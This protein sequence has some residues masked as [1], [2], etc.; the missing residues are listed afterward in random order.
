MVDPLRGNPGWLRRLDEPSC[1]RRG[2]Q[3]LEQQGSLGPYGRSRAREVSRPHG[4]SLASRHLQRGLGRGQPD[5]CDWKL[6][7]GSSPCGPDCVRVRTRAPDQDLFFGP[8]CTGAAGY[9][10]NGPPD[11]NNH[12]DPDNEVR[13]NRSCNSERE[14]DKRALV[15]QE[16]GHALGLAHADTR[17]SCMWERASEADTTPG[18]HQYYMLNQQ[19]Y[20]H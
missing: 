17:Q 2:G 18:P 1:L 16:L 11:S 5:R 4:K 7:D 15:C 8:N 12:W 14:R 20:D 10:T 6:A 3:P 19:I 9:W 13:F